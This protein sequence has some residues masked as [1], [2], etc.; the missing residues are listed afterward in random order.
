MPTK[1]LLAPIPQFSRTSYG[2]AFGGGG[3]TGKAF[4]GLARALASQDT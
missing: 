3:G 4:H 1:L 2:P